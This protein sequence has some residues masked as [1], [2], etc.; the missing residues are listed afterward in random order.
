MWERKKNITFVSIRDIVEKGTL[1]V[2]H[3]LDNDLGLQNRIC[4]FLL[5]L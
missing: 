4:S 5:L 2:S 1:A 3:P